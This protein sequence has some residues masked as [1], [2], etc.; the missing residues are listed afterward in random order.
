MSKLAGLTMMFC[1]HKTTYNVIAWYRSDSLYI[2]L[3][4]IIY[5][6][7]CTSQ[8]ITHLFT[9]WLTVASWR[10][11]VSWNLE[12]IGSWMICNNFSALSIGPPLAL[13]LKGIVV[14]CVRA[15][16]W[17][18]VCLSVRP[19]DLACSRDDSKNAF[20][21]YPA[22]LKAP[23]YCRTPSGWAGGRAAGQTSPVNTLTSIIFHG[24]FSNLARTFIVL[25][26]R[27]SSIMEVLPH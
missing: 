3:N 27:T 20:H 11:L 18:S 24:S 19:Y 4:Q 12:T 6:I 26:S 10:H 7:R 14:I 17:P 13:R 21:F 23:G 2:Q 1:H 22:A 25:R 16:V 15:S 5:A 9:C 8:T